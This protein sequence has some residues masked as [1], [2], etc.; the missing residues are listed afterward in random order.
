MLLMKA[1]YDYKNC[2][3]NIYRKTAYFN[4][5]K[6]LII[7]L[8]LIII[9]IIMLIVIILSLEYFSVIIMLLLNKTS[10][11]MKLFIN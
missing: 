8:M 3:N 5:N 10:L 1:D 4:T 7:K 6:I 11:T 2:F 9:L